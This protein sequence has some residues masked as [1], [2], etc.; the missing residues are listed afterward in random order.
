MITRLLPLIPLLA[1]RRRRARVQRGARIGAPAL[2]AL[3]AAA[4]ALL[5]P[6][7]PPQRRRLRRLAVRA[8]RP[9]RRHVGGRDRRREHGDAAA[10]ATGRPS[11]MD[12]D[13]A[14]VA[15]AAAHGDVVAPDTST[16]DPL[17][18]EAENAAA[19]E[20]G[21]IGGDAPEAPPA[22]RTRVQRARELS[23]QLDFRAAHV[24][25]HSHIPDRR[26]DP[27][28]ARARHALQLR[29]RPS[30]RSRS[31]CFIFINWFFATEMMQRQRRIQKMHKFRRDARARKASSP[32][33]TSARSSEL[34]R[35]PGRCTSGA[36][37]GSTRTGASGST[38]RGRAAALARASTR[39]RSTRSRSTRPSTGWLTRRGRPLGRADARRL[40]LRAEDEPLP[41]PHQEADRPARR[42][43]SATTS[44]SSRWSSRRKLGPIVWQLAPWFKRDDERLAYALG[45]L[46]AGDH[47]F[48]FRHESWFVPE[49]YE[50]LRERRVA[51]VIGDHPQRPWQPY[52]FTADWTLVRFHYGARGRR[53]N[54]SK[55]ELEEWAKRI[56]EWREQR[57]GLRLLQQRLG[58]LR[59]R[60]RPLAQEAPGRLVAAT[61]RWPGLPVAWSASSSALVGAAGVLRLVARRRSPSSSGVY[62]LGAL[63]GQLV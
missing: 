33:G 10:A 5:D 53:G 8:G 31:S 50:M 39:R 13:P 49:V 20:A 3:G 25:P 1:R 21:A 35:W 4:A 14:E 62:C 17:V 32:S 42:G 54:Y 37:A 46:P 44:G 40:R 52:E 12:A 48:E 16:D 7:P 63:F 23:R 55:T 22:T 9:P 11:T 30:W 6:P 28:R 2:L 15:A 41:D 57:R 59:G 29:H 27:P 45:Q 58:G 56:E 18:T 26:D 61:P 43:S 34:T 47:C 36:R 24:A 38:R 51:L 60:E 19:A